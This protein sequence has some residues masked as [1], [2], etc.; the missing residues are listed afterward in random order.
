MNSIISEPSAAISCSTLTVKEKTPI[1]AADLLND[2]V[3]PFFA[4]H[5]VPAESGPHRSRDGVLRRAGPRI[6][7]QLLVSGEH[8]SER[9]RVIIS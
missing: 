4:E 5:E 7:W 2:R 3:L 8:Q 1:T 9:R 6:C